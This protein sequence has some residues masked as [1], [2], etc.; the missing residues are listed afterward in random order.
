MEIVFDAQSKKKVATIRSMPI[1]KSALIHFNGTVQ[2]VLT[3][4]GHL[5]TAFVLAQ[6]ATFNNSSFIQ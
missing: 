6:L 4:K 3:I 1:F 5:F 2:F